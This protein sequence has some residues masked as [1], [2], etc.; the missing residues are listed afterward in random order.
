MGRFGGVVDTDA[1]HDEANDGESGEDEFV[2]EG[3]GDGEELASVGK[4]AEEVA[5]D[6]E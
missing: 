4:G 5:G 3:V 2:Q 6:E 1:F